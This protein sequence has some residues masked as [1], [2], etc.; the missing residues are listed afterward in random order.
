MV[1][2]VAYDV[3]PHPDCNITA[4]E[5]HLTSAHTLF[6]YRDW[7]FVPTVETHLCRRNAD[8]A[9]TVH[10]DGVLYSAARPE[11]VTIDFIPSQ[12]HPLTRGTFTAWKRD[13]LG[14]CFTSKGAYSSLFTDI[15]R[16]LTT[17][18]PCEG[19]A[20]PAA[21]PRPPARAQAA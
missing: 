19:T 16:Q 12:T 10:L 6:A 11:A 20:P 1:R 13:G 21:P 4:V 17:Q 7:G 15:I 14:R 8:T 3:P 9:I 5:V 2:F 18:T